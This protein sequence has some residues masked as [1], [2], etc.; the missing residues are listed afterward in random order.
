VRT[1]LLLDEMLSGAIVEQLR[2]RGHDVVAVV[3]DPAMT[4]FADE[5]ILAAATS[6]NR[7]VV[8]VN[9]RDFMVLD[10]RYRAA[11]RNHSGLVLVSSKS[12]PQ[13]RSF[14]GA[15]VGALEKLLTEEAPRINTIAFLQR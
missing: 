1:P 15:L 3:D 8:T 11:G 7:V 9:I 6:A 2:R 14:I 5:E 10:Q 4:G 12:F 13:D